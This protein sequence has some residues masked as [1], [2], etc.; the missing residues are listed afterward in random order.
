MDWGFLKRD[1]VE[2]RYALL[3][4]RP[5]LLMFDWR[6]RATRLEVVAAAAMLPLFLIPDFVFPNDSSQDDLLVANFVLWLIMFAGTAVRRMHDSSHA[7]WLIGVVLFP[8][9][10]W[11]VLLFHLFRNPDNSDNPF[12]PDP[13]DF[14]YPEAA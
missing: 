9:V 3:L 1:T 6:G 7:G 8:Y 11:L 13:R 5:F 14:L 2:R 10:G 4:A 12:G